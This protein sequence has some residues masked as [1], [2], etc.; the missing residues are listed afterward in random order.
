MFFLLLEKKNNGF[1]CGC[2]GGGG[3]GVGKHISTENM[4]SE[5]IV[6]H[7]ITIFGFCIIV[8]PNCK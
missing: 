3:G 5:I 4:H 1:V 2:V 8:S 7:F 6:W